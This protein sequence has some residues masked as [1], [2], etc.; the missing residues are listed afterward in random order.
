M[1]L[2]PY[3]AGHAKSQSRGRGADDEWLG[4][5]LECHHSSVQIGDIETI[6]KVSRNDE[7]LL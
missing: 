2:A 4:S 7:D 5:D 3:I 6:K 1:F